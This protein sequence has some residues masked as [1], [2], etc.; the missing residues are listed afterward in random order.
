MENMR[1]DYLSERFTIINKPPEGKNGDN[2]TSTYAQGNE[3]HTNPSV[4]SLIADNGVLRRCQDTIDERNTGWVVR[5]F[6]SENPIVS[7]NA[8]NKYG[9]DMFYSEP[10]FGYHY[11]VVASPNSNDTLINIGIEQ[12][13]NVLLGMQD[14]LK[15]TYRQRGV[16][17]VAIYADYNK[18][19][20]NSHPHLNMLSFSTIPPVIEDEIN[21][22]EKLQNESG[23][24]PM[25]RM[26][27]KE[28]NGPRQVLQTDSFVAYC[29]W[30]SS[31]PYEFWIAPKK[32]STQFSKIPQKDISDLALMIRTTL[33]G[34]N[35]TIKGGS[36]SIVFHLAAE[37]KRTLQIH[38]RI[39]I[40]PTTQLQTGLDIGYGIVLNTVSP[41]D[42]AIRLGASCRDEFSAL[43]GIK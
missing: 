35:K 19:A 21:K 5:I 28:I 23:M 2:G 40:Y 34:L 17:Y 43:M 14:R 6:E 12:W 33:G 11:V 22:Y 32:H 26:I 13:S 41:E 24:C 39:E 25:C 38:W 10:T 29:P 15:W 27:E 4:L 3:N 30:S 18:S 31:H 42:A 8:S 7:P 1:K 9:E 20:K 16:R 37:R 36:F